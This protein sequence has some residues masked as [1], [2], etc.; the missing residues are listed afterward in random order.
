M[1]WYNNEVKKRKKSFQEKNIL[2][3]KKKFKKKYLHF[4]LIR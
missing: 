4:F 1:S 2:G 3:E